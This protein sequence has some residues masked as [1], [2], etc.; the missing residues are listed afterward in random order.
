M[1]AVV[2]TPYALCAIL[3]V[4][5][6]LAESRRAR[7][8]IAAVGLWGSSVAVATLIMYG[9]AWRAWERGAFTLL[10]AGLL[11]MS[12]VWALLLVRLQ[13]KA[14]LPAVATLPEATGPGGFVPARAPGGR[15]EGGEQEQEEEE[16]GGRHW[17]SASPVARPGVQARWQKSGPTRQRY[18]SR[19]RR[20][21]VFARE[22]RKR[23]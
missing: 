3:A 6:L 15:A 14:P 4:C 11:T 18:E 10:W 20:V 22:R 21:P 9:V 19:K 5:L 13:H 17:V 16:H 8:R 7:L 12:I 23:G 1:I 2:S